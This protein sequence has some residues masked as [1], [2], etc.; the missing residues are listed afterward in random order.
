MIMRIQPLPQ[1]AASSENTSGSRGA[2]VRRADS[3]RS[4]LGK[5]VQ[6]RA[7]TEPDE[8]VLGAEEARRF[9]EVLHTPPVAVPALIAAMRRIR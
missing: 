3:P 2:V 1:A 9:V 6:L 4:E 8:T 5:V 7:S